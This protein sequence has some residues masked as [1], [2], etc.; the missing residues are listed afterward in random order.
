MVRRSGRQRNSLDP[1]G[2]A[3]LQDKFDL[4]TPVGLLASGEV[5]DGTQTMMPKGSEAWAMLLGMIQENGVDTDASVR[6]EAMRFYSMLQIA[7][8]TSLR[9]AA[10][11]DAG[12]LPGPEVSLGKLASV[13]MMRTWRCRSRVCRSLAEPTKSNTTSLPNA[14][15]VL[16]AS[17]D[18][19]ERAKPI[20]GGVS[21]SR[22]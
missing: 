15:S 9:A 4:S 2:E 13:R 12:Q 6:Q 22:S 14:S 21:A 5:D 7:R 11:I 3:G 10:A 1:E 20:P 8:F 17:L 18:Q 16:V 19:A